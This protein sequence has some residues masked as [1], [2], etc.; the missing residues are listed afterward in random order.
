MK[1]LGAFKKYREAE[2]GQRKKR[3]G[4]ENNMIMIE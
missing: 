1:A 4:T 2:Q 3:E